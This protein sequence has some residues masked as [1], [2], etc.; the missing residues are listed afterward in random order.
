MSATRI[1]AIEDAFYA[2]RWQ[3]YVN[4]HSRADRVSALSNMLGEFGLE[5]I[6]EQFWPMVGE[7]WSDS[8][9]SGREPARRYW[10]EIWE[11]IFDEEGQR[12]P[13]SETAMSEADRAVFDALPEIVTVWRGYRTEPADH[14]YG[15]SWSLSRLIA[16]W[17]ATVRNIHGTAMIAKARL[18]KSAVFAFLNGRKEAE[19]VARPELIEIVATA[20]IEEPK[21]EDMR[22]PSC[23]VTVNGDGLQ[24]L[25]SYQMREAA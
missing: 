14:L 13:F 9:N 16:E 17:F 12:T 23:I 3:D 5:E 15:L 19:I 7:H 21:I 1:E 2:C 20:E 18:P 4:F 6:A 24:F 8:E 10:R 25:H 11:A 22:R